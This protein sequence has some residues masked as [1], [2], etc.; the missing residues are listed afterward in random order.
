MK[1]VHGVYGAYQVLLPPISKGGVGSIYKTTTPA[2]VYKEYHSTA[3]APSRHALDRLVR[4]GRDTVVSKRLP[5]G[6]NPVASV[7]W[8]VD[9]ISDRSGRISG[10]ILPAIPSALFNEFGKPR[11]LDFLI[12][13]RAQPPQAGVRVPLLLRMAEI[14]AHLD[15][16]SLVHGD[17]NG[18][19]LAWQ[20]APT[21]TMYLID[22]DGIVGK[23]PP[24]PAGVQA[25]GWTDPRVAEGLVPAH[26]HL[27]DWYALALAMY[28]GLLLVPGNITEKK[29]GSWPKPSHIPPQLNPRVASLLHRALDNPLDAAGRPSPSTWVQTLLEVYVPGGNYDDRELRALDKVATP[30]TPTKPKAKPKQPSVT[31]PNPVRQTPPPRPA[32]A[33]SWAPPPPPP[34]PPAPTWAPPPPHIPAP[35]PPPPPAPR[36]PGGFGWFGQAALRNAPGWHVTSVVLM[37]CC[38]YVGLVHLLVSAV[39][40]AKAPSWVRGRKRALVFCG[41]YG[42]LTL[43][44]MGCALF[45]SV[46][47]SET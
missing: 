33:P 21:P 12:M 41:V 3:K 10:V 30:S 6:S 40:V 28:R 9:I 36:A 18:K 8:P 2:F 42:A 27:S 19:N 5:V 32:P 24:P 23:S 22:C 11:T 1:S 39:Q 34:P 29:S 14:L 31:P 35:P 20:G 25:L 26:D 46:F 37:L 7:N 13:A 38:P 43:S 44:V 45:S 15:A 47:S 4:I 17:I 16:Q